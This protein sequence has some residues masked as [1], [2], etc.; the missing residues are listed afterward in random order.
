MR[1]MDKSVNFMSASKT[2]LLVCLAWLL[3]ASI[4]SG[5]GNANPYNI[6]RNNGDGIVYALPYSR[7][8]IRVQVERT[9][10]H[11]GKLHLY[12][13]KYFSQDAKAEASTTYRLGAAQIESIGVADND[14]KYVVEF[15]SG[16]V[17]D[18]VTLNR[19]GVLCAINADQ[20]AINAANS[21]SKFELPPNKEAAKLLAAL[22]QEYSLASSIGK[23]AEVAANQVFRIRES[24]MDLL[25]G[26][27][28]SQTTDGTALQLLID[29]LKSQEQAILQLFYG[30]ESSY[31]S[32]EKFLMNP[33]EKL[34]D[35]I[36]FRFSPLLGI[37]EADDLAG[38][39]VKL[40]MQATDLAPEL[41]EKAA[42]KY[43]KSLKGIVYNLPGK[44]LVQ[45]RHGTKKLFDAELPIT[46][47]GV[48][49]ALAPRLFKQKEGQSISIIFDEE[50]GA[51]KHITET[52]Q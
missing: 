34:H 51:I 36:L 44:A 29:Q 10:F 16:N 45:L 4:L 31:W 50:T 17:A 39:P 28:S 13:R 35:Y 6:A 5:Q 15:R 22:P 11:P 48:R 37:L 52:N 32:E 20:K 42:A 41:D 7:L 1:S 24:L 40:T 23:Q 14:S 21:K 2:G 43:E 38:E 30:S 18:F 49:K 26:Q 3:S 46:Q 19:Q 33:K 9:E 47:F 25:T 8:Q 12:A 27:A